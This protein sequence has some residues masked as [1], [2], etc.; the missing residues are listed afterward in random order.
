MPEP[1]ELSPSVSRGTECCPPDW[2]KTAAPLEPRVSWPIPEVRVSEPPERLIVPVE[3]DATPR[4]RLLAK[5]EVPPLWLNAALPPL[6][7][8]AS[9][10]TNRVAEL[11]T[12]NATCVPAASAT[13]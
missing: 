8:L 1:S 12:L 7:M 6:A 2:L 3:G 10:P 4:R 5:V 13:L 9:P 11:L